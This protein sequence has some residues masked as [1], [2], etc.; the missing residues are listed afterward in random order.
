LERENGNLTS[1][2]KHA[3]ELTSL[4]PGDLDAKKLLADLQA[5]KR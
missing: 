2:I 3:E 1:A 5:Q 4:V